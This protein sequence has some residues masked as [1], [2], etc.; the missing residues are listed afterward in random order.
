MYIPKNKKPLILSLDDLDYYTWMKN[1]GFADKLVLVND[2]VETE[3][4]NT[5]FNVLYGVGIDGYMKYFNNYLV[6]DRI[7]IDGYRLAHNESFCA[8]I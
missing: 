8:L 2:I 4:T 6:M 5:G 7:D 1:D 3:S